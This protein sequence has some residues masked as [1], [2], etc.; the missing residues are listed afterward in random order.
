M[1]ESTSIDLSGIKDPAALEII[2][3]LLE[4]NRKL[5][6]RIQALEEKIAR[7]EKNSST[8]SKPPSSDI[9]KATTRAAPTWDTQS[10]RVSRSTQATSGSYFRQRK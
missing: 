10:G 1:A 8:S 2:K 6:E 4:E 5:R 9:T 7:L 3:F